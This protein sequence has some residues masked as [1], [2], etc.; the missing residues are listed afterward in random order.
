MEKKL[1]KFDEKK[2]QIFLGDLHQS[3][4]QA[5]ALFD[6]IRAIIN[7]DLTP[8]NL[9]DLYG[10]RGERTAALIES[11]VRLEL[12]RAGITSATIVKAAVNGDLEQYFAIF[13]NKSNIESEYL[14]YLYVADGKVFIKD[15]ACDEA[16]ELFSSYITTQEGLRIYEAQQLAIKAAGHLIELIPSAT[17]SNLPNL[18]IPH[19]HEGEPTPPPLNYDK[20]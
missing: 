11:A 17:W 9:A 6:Q 4:Q 20:L 12:K 16:Q 19:F 15:N 1:I 18:I 10:G 8:E 2:Y 14:Q 13:N 7:V 3:Q 5:D